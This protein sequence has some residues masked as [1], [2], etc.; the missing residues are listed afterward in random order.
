M[1]SVRRLESLGAFMLKIHTLDVESSRT[2]VAIECHMGSFGSCRFAQEQVNSLWGHLSH[3][4]QGGKAWVKEV[5]SV[6]AHLDGSEPVL[7]R[8]EGVE[9]RYG[10]VQQWLRR[11]RGGRGEERR[12]GGWEDIKSKA[13]IW[14]NIKQ[15]GFEGMERNCG[16]DVCERMQDGEGVC[17]VWI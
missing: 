5:V 11:P 10:S 16:R 13:G 8:A 15:G 9:V 7:Y 1:Q 3:Q 12:E 14:C 17:A 4:L 2:S 6:L